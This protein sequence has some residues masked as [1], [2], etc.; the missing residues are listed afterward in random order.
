MY[1]NNITVVTYMCICIYPYVQKALFF[2]VVLGSKQNWVEITEVSHIS[3]DPHMHSLPHY[4]HSSQSSIFV[5]I[6]EPPL[7]LIVTPSL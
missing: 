6:G 7:T 3:P 5:I 1:C 4:Q 2:R